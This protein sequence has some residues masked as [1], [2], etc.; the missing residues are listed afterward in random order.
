MGRVLLAHLPAD[1][2]SAYLDRTPLIARTA[3][4]L[5][6]RGRLLEALEKVRESGYALVDQ[7]LE[8]GLRSIAVA[9]HNAAGVVAAINVGTQ[10]A[11]LP[12]ADLQRRVLPELRKTALELSAH[13]GFR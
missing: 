5:T 3:K 4:T 8:I 11:R 13:L 10:A 12:L 7:E 6:Q 9:V 2:L 1:E